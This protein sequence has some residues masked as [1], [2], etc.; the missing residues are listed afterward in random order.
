MN[1]NSLHSILAFIVSLVFCL[2]GISQEETY[3]NKKDRPFYGGQEWFDKERKNMVE[4]FRNKELD[5]IYHRAYI[6]NK[7]RGKVYNYRLLMIMEK[8]LLLFIKGEY[9]KLLNEIEKN[10]RMYFE[11]RNNRTYIIGYRFQRPPHEFAENSFHDEFNRT[12]LS[13]LE[14]NSHLIIDQIKNAELRR[15]EL[16][17]LL[18]YLHLNIHYLDPCNGRNKEVLYEY[19]AEFMKR[20]KY[21]RYVSL[22]E[23]YTPYRT[24]RSNWGTGFSFGLLGGYFIGQ[25]TFKDHASSFLT[26]FPF[27]LSINYNNFYAKVQGSWTSF[28]FEY[29]GLNQFK[30][31]P[32]LLGANG[33]AKIGYTFHVPNSSLSISPFIGTNRFVFLGHLIEK[34]EFV[35]EEPLVDSFTW[36]S[37][38][39]IYGVNIDLNFDDTKHCNSQQRN[40]RAFHRFQFG[41]S[42]I[43]VN[44]GSDLFESNLF[45]VQYVLG[46]QNQRQ[47]QTPIVR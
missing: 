13:Y 20:F 24:S 33:I 25:G 34:E 26:Y 39:P 28:D 1:F 3:K 43:S 44:K 45:F 5:S 22:V 8:E 27:G 30:L 6:Y 12:L 35:K 17:F 15:D 9:K 10:E 29:D 2:N 31:S 37:N 42:S 40:Y 14:Y 19:T 21:S 18:Y 32:P 23:K 7:E 41:V 16:N 46:I 47:T 36:R 11:Q 4:K 38:A